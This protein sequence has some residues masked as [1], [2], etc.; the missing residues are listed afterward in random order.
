MVRELSDK[1][2]DC[3]KGL[4]RISWMEGRTACV[5]AGGWAT[6][7]GWRA[8]DRV[9]ALLCPRNKIVK[10]I[11][12]NKYDAHRYLWKGR[13]LRE[14]CENNINKTLREY[15]EINT[16]K[17]LTEDCEINT[18]KKYSEKTAKLIQIKN[19]QRRLWK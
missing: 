10:I 13:L 5:G 8:C 4:L 2:T 12:I 9:D 15:C 14:D 7:T 3:R 1:P 16:N 6:V 11:K 19:T 18:N 17:M